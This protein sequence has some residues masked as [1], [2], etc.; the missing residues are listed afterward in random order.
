V[1]QEQPKREH[2]LPVV[3]QHR[4][5]RLGAA[6]A[7]EIEVTRRD[8]R[9]RQVT[10]ALHADN[11]SLHGGQPCVGEPVPPELAR[12]GEQVQ[13]A[14][15]QRRRSPMQAEPR[16][17]QRPVEAQAV[18]GDQPGVGRNGALQRRQQRRLVRMIRQHQ[19]FDREALAVPSAE[20][21]QER[22]GARRG[23]Q[24]GRLG[25]Q[26]DQGTSRVNGIGERRELLE[27]GG[28]HGVT[29][30]QYQPSERPAL[31]DPAERGREPC[32]GVR[33]AG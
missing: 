2:V 4:A 8:Q 19:L 23:A 17:Q 5:Q 28:Q 11:A 31:H 25:I 15:M 3:V 26:A 22:H 12:H 30:D 29:A 20:S 1:R 7:E 6:R 18:V 14:R 24:P 27:G 32:R 9:A 33:V 13:M 10:A 16:H 21:N